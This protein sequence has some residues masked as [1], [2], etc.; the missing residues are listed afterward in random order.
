MK[1]PFAQLTSAEPKGVEGARRPSIGDPASVSVCLYGAERDTI[2]AEDRL[3]L[4][5]LFEINA[6][7]AGLFDD[8]AT[9]E[10]VLVVFKRKASTFAIR[11]ED[12]NDI[13][14]SA[15]KKLR[16]AYLLRRCA[17]RLERSL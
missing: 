2:N 5:E 17:D 8:G 16:L 12:S 3:G 14:E 9:D 1:Y 4:E 13:S 11:K 7:T 6:A 10:E 15:A